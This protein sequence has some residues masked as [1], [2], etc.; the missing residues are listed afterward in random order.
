MT[1]DEL[2]GTGHPIRRIVKATA[3]D[4]RKIWVD[5]EGGGA[6]V[7]DLTEHLSSSSVFDRVV[8]DDT[9]F[10]L[11]GL[12]EWGWAICWPDQPEA[13]IPTSVLERLAN[14]QTSAF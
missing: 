3:L 6:V 4:D 9:Y 1:T 8:S 12:E 10:Q 14:E 5:W 11:V 2:I 7:I 13:S